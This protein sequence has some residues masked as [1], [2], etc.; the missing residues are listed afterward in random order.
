MSWII[1]LLAAPPRKNTVTGP[2]VLSS[3]G[4][5]T[6]VLAATALQLDHALGFVLL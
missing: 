4:L 2:I 1:V 3:S 5:A 6:S